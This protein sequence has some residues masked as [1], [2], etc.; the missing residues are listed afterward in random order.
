MILLDSRLRGNDK[1]GDG[2][3]NYSVIPSKEGIQETCHPRENG[4]PGNMI[5]L[6]SRLRGND[7]KGDGNDREW[8]GNDS[9]KYSCHPLEGGDPG[10]MIL[11]DSRLR[12]NDQKGDG[13]DKKG[14]GSD[15]YNYSVISRRKR[16]SRKYNSSRFPP[17]RE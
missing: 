11:L 12:G 5:L 4:D 8:R 13:N 15:S 7:K 16:G 6:D 9:Y 2:N 14:D 17:P 10:N 1:K 3:D